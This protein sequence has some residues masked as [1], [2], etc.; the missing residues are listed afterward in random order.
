MLAQAASWD[1]V[2]SPYIYVFYASFLV[3]FLFTPVMRTVAMYF[4]IIDEPDRIRKMHRTP[5]A[6]LGGVAVFLGVLAGLA[7]SQFLTLHRLEPGWPDQLVIKFSIVVGACV[8]V[9]LGLWDDILKIR[10]AVKIA[11][12]VFAAA[13]LL[14]DGVGTQVAGP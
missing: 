1:D 11:G 2:L 3:A 5:V 8:I 4:N 10:P 12:Q 7:A 6:Y 13:L 9:L 14:Y